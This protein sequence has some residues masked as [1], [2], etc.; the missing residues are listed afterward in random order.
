MALAFGLVGLS[1]CCCWL[2]PS[3]PQPLAPLVVLAPAPIPVPTS[4]PMVGSEGTD[5]RGEPLRSA[6]MLGFQSLFQARRFTELCAYITELE[7]DFER[8]VTHESWPIQAL[9]S[10]SVPNPEHRAI[11]DAWIAEMPDCWAAHAARG[12]YTASVGFAQRGERSAM[13]TP[14]EAFAAMGVSLSRAAVDLSRSLE[15]RPRQV[16]A[17]VELLD[18]ATAM[19]DPASL[20]AVY[21]AAI[22][23][24]PDCLELRID[25]LR[26]LRP[27]WG[28]A[29]GEIEAALAT[30]D[31]SRRPGLSVLRGY[32]DYDLCYE[33]RGHDDDAA[34]AACDRAVATAPYWR[35]LVER[36]TVHRVRGEMNEA[37]ADFDRVL[38]VRPRAAAAMTERVRVLEELHRY[39][40]AAEQL[41]LV[42]HIA[43]EDAA[44]I[45]R[46]QELA[47][48]IAAQRD[49]ARAQGRTADAE[50][51]DAIL[52]DVLPPGHPLRPVHPAIAP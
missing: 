46:G 33:L 31:S 24:C 9:Q 7:E 32:L 15:M 28:G 26:N 14:R 21:D 23:S 27:R 3:P 20:H 29:P 41:A 25:Y 52:F 10:F 44:L 43:P 19:S 47:P 5:E 30:V 2:I 34:L 13:N 22:A 6:D 51:W 17:P 16:A 39:A 37:L 38:A 50:H 18:I 8:D 12:Y 1:L 36:G 4:L 42:V 11:H 35:Y 45:A 40:E 49:T 48:W